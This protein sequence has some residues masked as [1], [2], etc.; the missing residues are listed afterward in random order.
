[1]I[2]AAAGANDMGKPYLYMPITGPTAARM[3]ATARAIPETALDREGV[4]DNP[5]ITLYYDIPTEDPAV[6]AEA[7]HRAP[8]ARTYLD[9]VTLWEHSRRNVL[10]CL[11]DSELLKTYTL[12]VSQYF[13]KM[14]QLN[15]H[16]TLAYLR[17][18]AYRSADEKFTL[19]QAATAGLVPLRQEILSTR[20]VFV[21][22]AKQRHEIPLGEVV[23]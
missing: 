3:L 22:S 16:A 5:H 6:V 10:V 1:M 9:H 18:D 12:R 14:Y 15:A 19:L 8:Y 2:A 7:L 13:E 20:L 21:D 23:K 11:A 17:S 4:E